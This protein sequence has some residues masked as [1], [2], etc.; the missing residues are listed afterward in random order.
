MVEENEDTS[1][2]EGWQVFTVKTLRVTTKAV[3]EIDTGSSKD[4]HIKKKRTRF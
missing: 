1:E 3:M 4:Y 2:E